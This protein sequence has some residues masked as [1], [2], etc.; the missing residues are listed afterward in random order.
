[1]KLPLTVAF[2]S[3]IAGPIC[4]VFA[5]F[6]GIHSID[7]HIISIYCQNQMVLVL[8]PEIHTKYSLR[9]SIV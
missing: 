6:G 7:L 1:M 5:H 9:R 8:T 4:N 2:Y 3:Q